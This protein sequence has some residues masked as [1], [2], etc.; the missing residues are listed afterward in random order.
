[1]VLLYLDLLK[2]FENCVKVYYLKDIHACFCQLPWVTCDFF[3]GFSNHMNSM[4]LGR[5]I[6]VGT[7]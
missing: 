2:F 3:S 7:N 1:M 4:E 6:H 5:L